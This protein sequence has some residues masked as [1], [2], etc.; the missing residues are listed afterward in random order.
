MNTSIY[1]EIAERIDEWDEGG[2]RNDVFDI[3]T[4]MLA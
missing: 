2:W 1:V 4:R 3:H